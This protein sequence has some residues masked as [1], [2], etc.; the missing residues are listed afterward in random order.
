MGLGIS[1]VSIQLRIPLSSTNASLA[2]GVNLGLSVILFASTIALSICLKRANKKADL[3]EAAFGGDMA[4][5]HKEAEVTQIE[6]T[7]DATRRAG[8]PMMP[9][10][11]I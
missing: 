7:G 9:R 2:W 11:D 3:A 6:R 1:W 8:E 10:Y 5:D 4:T